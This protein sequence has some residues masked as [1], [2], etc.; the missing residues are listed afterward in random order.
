MRLYFCWGTMHVMKNF[1]YF[2]GIPA[3]FLTFFS[4]GFAQ[5][6]QEYIPLAQVPGLTPGSGKQ[7]LGQYINSIYTLSI[8]IGAVLAV[9]MIV[10]G[11]LQYMGTDIFSKKGEGKTRIQNAL[12]GLGLLLASFLILQ[13]VNNDLTSLEVDLDPANNTRQIGFTEDENGNPQAILTQDNFDQFIEQE[14]KKTQKYEDQGYKSKCTRNFASN[15]ARNIAELKKEYFDC[16]EGVR[17]KLV[18]DANSGKNID[19]DSITQCVVVPVRRGLDAEGT[20]VSC[21]YYK[22]K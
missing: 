9:L 7:A 10:V 15:T 12:L 8:G 4:F 22:K 11:G 5:E 6:P 2:F 13:T 14:K 3:L 19:A 18:E 21:A 17:K 1:L 16:D 20:Y